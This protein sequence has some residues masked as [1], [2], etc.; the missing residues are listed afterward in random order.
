MDLFVLAKQSTPVFCGAAAVVWTI[1]KTHNDVGFE[2]QFL[3]I[4]QEQFLPD[5]I[6]STF[7]KCCRRTKGKKKLKR[8]LT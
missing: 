7:G 2:Q 1:R 8:G 5:V 3:M 4:E 6:A